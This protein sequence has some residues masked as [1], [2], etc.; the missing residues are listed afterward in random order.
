MFQYQSN[1]AY[2]GAQYILRD[3]NK[4]SIKVKKPIS[5]EFSKWIEDGKD[6]F[7]TIYSPAYK[8]NI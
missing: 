5:G 8:A 2:L 6:V 7:K 4:Y 1:V 3:F